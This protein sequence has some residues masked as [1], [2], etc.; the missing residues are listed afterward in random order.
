MLCAWT[1]PSPPS[2]LTLTFDPE[3]RCVTSCLM[4]HHIKPRQVRLGGFTASTLH[5]PWG[6]GREETEDTDLSD[7]ISL[8]HLAPAGGWSQAQGWWAPTQGELPSGM[9]GSL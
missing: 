7:V 4:N 8:C 9:G 5:P 6:Q 1:S 2:L 3:P